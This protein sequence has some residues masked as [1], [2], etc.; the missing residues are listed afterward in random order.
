MLKNFSGFLC[1]LTRVYVDL[2]F[3]LP[4]GQ[5]LSHVVGGDLPGYTFL[6]SS[7]SR[8]TGMGH[9]SVVDQYT[10]EVFSQSDKT[11]NP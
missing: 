7:V 8:T 4:F 11:I 3:T 5:R 9:S 6:R 10:L 1:K 2:D